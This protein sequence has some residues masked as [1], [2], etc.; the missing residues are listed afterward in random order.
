MMAEKK[1][2]LQRVTIYLESDVLKRL[3]LLAVAK[4][5]DVSNLVNQAASEYLDR[6]KADLQRLAAELAAEWKIKGH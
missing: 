1:K 4:D 5:N 2:A 3:K 6:Q